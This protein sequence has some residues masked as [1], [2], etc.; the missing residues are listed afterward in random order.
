[1]TLRGPAS[2]GERGNIRSDDPAGAGK[3]WKKIFTVE[4]MTLRGPVGSKKKK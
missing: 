1:M 2:T 4:R 3:K